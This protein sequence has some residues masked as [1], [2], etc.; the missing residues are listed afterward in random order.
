MIQIKDKFI[1]EAESTSLWAQYNGKTIEV[2]QYPLQGNMNLVLV[3]LEEGSHPMVVEVNWLKPLQ[4]IQE[5]TVKMP[6]NL[7]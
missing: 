3:F 6:T 2:L 1:L 5:S 4:Y 7:E